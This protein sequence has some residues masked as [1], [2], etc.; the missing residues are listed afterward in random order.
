MTIG[1]TTTTAPS[2]SDVYPMYNQGV[3]TQHVGYQNQ[4]PT[5]SVVTAVPYHTTQRSWGGSGRKRTNDVAITSSTSSNNTTNNAT[6]DNVVTAKSKARSERKRTREKQRREGVNKQFAELTKVLTRIELEERE[7]QERKDRLAAGESGVGSGVTSLHSVRLPFIAPNN[8]V[9]LIT[10]A[11][12][13]LQHLHRVSKRQQ[14]EVDR[15]EDKLRDAKKAGDDTA[16]KL[17]DVLF[18]MGLQSRTQSYLG[19]GGIVSSEV[20]PKT[21]TTTVMDSTN[22][23]RK[24]GMDATGS[25]N[26]II[27]AAAKASGATQKNQQVSIVI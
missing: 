14:E 15:L 6:N 13:H 23:G 7:E 22:N 5:T 26:A 2:S 25:S 24:P 1:A 8:I 17:K 12:V 20:G 16:T 27:A 4:Q 21:S 19:G 11:I 3:S 9:D 10:C 18:N